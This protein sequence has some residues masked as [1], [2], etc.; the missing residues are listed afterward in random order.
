MTW[1]EFIH[2][3]ILEY[4][5]RAGSRTFSLED[6]YSE[7]EPLIV[8]FSPKNNNREAK[9]RQILQFLRDDRV[10]EFV[11]NH[12]HYTLRDI[13]LLT[14]EKQELATIDISKEPPERKEYVVE[15]FVR[16]VGWAKKAREIYGEFCLV[17]DCKNT[18]KKEDG[19]PYIEVHHITPLCNGGED[20]V[21]NLSVLCAH[22]HKMAHF[23]LKYDRDKLQSLLHDKTHAILK[24]K[25][26]FLP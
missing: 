3:E 13:D 12:G 9:V 21:W 25:G 6:F 1:K 4:C 15:T 16:N 2:K 24:E 14:Q 5:N 8:D 22:H 7:K 20:G 17:P 10:L 23:A 19:S 11:D 26:Y 18:F